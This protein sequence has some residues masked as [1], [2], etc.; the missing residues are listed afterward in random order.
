MERRGLL[1][2]SLHP[3]DRRSMLV[4]LTEAGRSAAEKAQRPVEA[5]EHRIREAI[6][7]EDFRGFQRV[8][9]AISQVTGV[10]VRPDS[11]EK[12]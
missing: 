6:S 9:E 11:K 7:E 2:R 10:R 3:T 5:L 1:E 12:R 8:L 4:A